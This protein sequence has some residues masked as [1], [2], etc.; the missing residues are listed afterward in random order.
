MLE[1]E[2]TAVVLDV[3]VVEK[4]EVELVAV[5]AEFEVFWH[6]LFYVKIIFLEVS[7]TCRVFY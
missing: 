1:S 3:L 6:V 2:V 5:R 4:D 7:K